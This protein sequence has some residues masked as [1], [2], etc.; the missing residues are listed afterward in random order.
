MRLQVQRILF[1]PLG[2]LYQS[3]T[4][5]MML[6]PCTCWHAGTFFNKFPISRRFNSF[7]R[8]NVRSNN[9]AFML[10]HDWHTLVENDECP[11]FTGRFKTPCPQA[12]MHSTAADAFLSFF[13]MPRPHL[14]AQAR[15]SWCRPP[16]RAATRA[17]HCPQKHSH[18]L[19]CPAVA[20]ACPVHHGHRR[21]LTPIVCVCVWL[22]V[23]VYMCAWPCARPYIGCRI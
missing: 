5:Q 20:T 10:R 1:S 22:R 6:K 7:N 3:V 12:C 23:C 8:R 9:T 4:N 19:L 2:N 13:A 16:S 14:R 17:K 15:R 21:C 11:P 18:V